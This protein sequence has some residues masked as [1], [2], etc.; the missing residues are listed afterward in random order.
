MPLPETRPFTLIS[1]LARSGYAKAGV[2]NHVKQT[3]QDPAPNIGI[4]VRPFFIEL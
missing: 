2:T 1:I 3:T 4:L